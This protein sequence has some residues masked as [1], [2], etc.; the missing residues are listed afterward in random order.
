LTSATFECQ[1]ACWREDHELQ[2]EGCDQLIQFRLVQ[3]DRHERETRQNFYQITSDDTTLDFD[4]RVP[5][6]SMSIFFG[7]LFQGCYAP[8][9]RDYTKRQLTE[10]CDMLNASKGIEVA[11]SK[12][13]GDFLLGS[14]AAFACSVTLVDLED[15][16]SF[17]P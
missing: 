16:A 6:G 10:A 5:R 3:N 17:Y 7:G 13:L 9:V 14:A 1:E 11:L 8:L 4:K 15:G 2:G 12:S